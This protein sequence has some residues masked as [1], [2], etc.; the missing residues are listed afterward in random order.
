V[1][2]PALDGVLRHLTS[3]GVQSLISQPPT[4]E[5]LFLRH[6]ETGGRDA[7]PAGRPDRAGMPR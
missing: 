6:Y 4:L 3:F 5:D 1:D 2:N 7:E